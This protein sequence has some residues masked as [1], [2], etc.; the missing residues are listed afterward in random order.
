MFS[1]HNSTLLVPWRIL[2]IIVCLRSTQTK[3]IMLFLSTFHIWL[4]FFKVGHSIKELFFYKLLM[5]TCLLIRCPEF[6]FLAKKAPC[7]AWRC[8]N[9]TAFCCPAAIICFYAEFNHKLQQGFSMRMIIMTTLINLSIQLLP[10]G[11]NV[12][13]SSSIG[14]YCC[15][16][17]KISHI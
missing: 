4:R 8:R 15:E 7:M 6:I 3:T 17:T 2:S 12:I 5:K 16:F 11:R 14:I 13:S 10:K 9:N 1:M